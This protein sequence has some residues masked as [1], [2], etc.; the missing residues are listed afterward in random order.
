MPRA[1]RY[2]V[3]R[4][5]WHIT[6]RCHNRDFLFRSIDD[7]T[8]WMRWLYH[9]KN[10]FNISILNYIVTCNHIHL[11][12]SD[13]E[14]G[15]KIPEFMQ[16]LQGRTAQDYNLRR[17]RKGAFWEDRYHA[18]AVESGEHV[19]KCMTYISMN[20]VRAGIVDNPLKWKESGFYEIQHPKKRY[21]ILDYSEINKVFSFENV[22]QLQKNQQEWVNDALEQ[23]ELQRDRR[24]TEAIAVGSKNYLETFSKQLGLRAQFRTIRKDGEYYEL[25]EAEIPYNQNLY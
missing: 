10:R 21:V 11:L 24:W 20:M 19:R 3:P 23:K 5:I 16:L 18:T 7:R 6:H 12:I 17:N 4:Q 14:G 2:F 25:S 8:Y 15:S 22:K 13:T 1:N 9:A